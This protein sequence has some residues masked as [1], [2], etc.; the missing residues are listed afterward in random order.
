MR[1]QGFIQTKK[2]SISSSYVSQDRIFFIKETKSFGA[3]KNS[4][5]TVNIYAETFGVFYFR[6]L[7]QLKFR[8][9]TNLYLSYP[10]LL[11][12]NKTLPIL[13]SPNLRNGVLGSV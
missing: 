13:K 7:F 8:I 9:S 5:Y 3:L 4:F 11:I 6:T 2:D 1:P 10:D 12:K